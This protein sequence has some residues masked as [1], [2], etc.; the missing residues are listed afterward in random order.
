MVSIFYFN[1]SVNMN[2]T[3]SDEYHC[4]PNHHTAGLR[5]TNNETIKHLYSV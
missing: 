4:Y 3:S 5:A 2:L 1:S